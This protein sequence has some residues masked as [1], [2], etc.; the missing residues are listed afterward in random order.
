MGKVIKKGGGDFAK[1]GSSGQMFGKGYASP[2]E[3]GVSG[4]SSQGSSSG[5]FAQGGSGKMFG[6]GSARLAESGV[7]GKSSQ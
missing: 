4:K 2:A 3:S 1:G 6:K 5:K 7:S